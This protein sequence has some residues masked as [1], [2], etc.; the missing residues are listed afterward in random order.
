MEIKIFAGLIKWI[1]N[2]DKVV[3]YETDKLKKRNYSFAP[4]F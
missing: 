3:R 4:V 1:I 2:G